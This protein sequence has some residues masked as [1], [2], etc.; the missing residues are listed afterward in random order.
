MEDHEEN[1]VPI[2]TQ[3]KPIIFEVYCSTVEDATKN[4]H[5]YLIG[6]GKTPSKWRT[7]FEWLGDN[8]YRVTAKARA[9]K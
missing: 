9:T 2:A 8:T 4:A 5:A 1:Q 3:F 6:M 7:E